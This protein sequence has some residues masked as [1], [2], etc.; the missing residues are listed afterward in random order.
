MEWTEVGEC[1]C[2]LQHRLLDELVVAALVGL[3]EGSGV[4]GVELLVELNALDRKSTERHAGTV[5]VTG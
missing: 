4:V 3:P 2:E 5:A 1:L